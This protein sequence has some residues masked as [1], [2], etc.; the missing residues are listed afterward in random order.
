MLFGL[1]AVGS[2]CI[3]THLLV[4]D[5]IPIRSSIGPHV[6][7]AT[8]AVNAMIATGVKRS[9]TFARLVRDLDDTDVIVY[10]EIV[11]SLPAGLDGRLSF[12][13]AAG[14]FRYLR[15][16]VPANTGKHDLI[17]VMGHE[18]QHAMEIAEHANVQDSEGVAS[19]YKLIGLQA[20]GVDRY[21]T[22][23]ARSVGRRVRAELL[24]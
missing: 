16:Q 5:A 15:I 18:L 7:G 6:R 22:T 20:H 4:A 8:P 2:L 12:S 13:T 24:E 19:L 23:E 3:A 9:T 11:K 10:V 1:A 17:A 21:D 14:G